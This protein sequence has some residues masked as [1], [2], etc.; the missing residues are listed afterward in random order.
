MVELKKEVIEEF[1]DEGLTERGKK[2]LLEYL[3]RSAR[4]QG[5]K[6]K[7]EKLG[8]ENSELADQFSKMNL[9]DPTFAAV[10]V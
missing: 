2:K 7:I 6:L 8:D 9:H 1:A 5:Y 3:V 4:G 10:E